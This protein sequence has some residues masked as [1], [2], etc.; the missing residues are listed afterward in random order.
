VCLC[1]T[2]YLKTDN[3]GIHSGDHPDAHKQ[4]CQTDRPSVHS[5]HQEIS[6]PQNCQIDGPSV[7]SEHNRNLATPP[8]SSVSSDKAAQ[9]IIETPLN[10]KDDLNV[11]I[12][13]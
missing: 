11:H 12:K 9:T 13:G 10:E 6:H 4:K 1:S 5:E 8:S 3:V 2:F 7:Q